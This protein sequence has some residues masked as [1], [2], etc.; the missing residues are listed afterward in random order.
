[1]SAFRVL[2]LFPD[3]LVDGLSLGWRSIV[4]GNWWLSE[5]RVVCHADTKIKRA[6]LQFQSNMGSILQGIRINWI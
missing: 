2:R 4:S 5:C 6:R 1:M 3:I